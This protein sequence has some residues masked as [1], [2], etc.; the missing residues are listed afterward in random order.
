MLLHGVIDRLLIIL[1]VCAMYC[2]S[3]VSCFFILQSQ[4]QLMFC[5]QFSEKSFEYCVD[6]IEQHPLN[7]LFTV[8]SNVHS[9]H[10]ENENFMFSKTFPLSKWHTVMVHADCR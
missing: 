7:I 5:G 3:Q 8:L 4:K 2:V 6:N 10:V 1:K 9:K